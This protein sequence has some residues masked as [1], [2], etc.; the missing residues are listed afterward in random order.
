MMSNSGDEPGP[1]EEDA[2][3]LFKVLLTAT[4][5]VLMYVFFLLFRWLSA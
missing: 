4:P 2:P 5:F 3:V 1:D